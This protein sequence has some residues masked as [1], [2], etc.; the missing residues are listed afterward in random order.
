MSFESTTTVD[1]SSTAYSS[2]NVSF[3][4]PPPLPVRQIG[5][6]ES[7]AAA[8]S[9][10]KAFEGDEVSF[11]FLDTP[12]KK[13]SRRSSD[14]TWKLHT[15]IMEYTVA[16]HCRKGLVL[17]IGEN[18]EGVAL[19][20]PPGHN[21][22]DWWTMFR[23]GMWKL[24]FKLSKEGRKRW[25]REFL[26]KLHDTKEEVMAERDPNSWYL[27]YIGVIPDAQGRGYSRRL[28]EHVTVMADA[29]NEPCYVESSA[30]K[31]VA[32]YERFGFQRR[33]ELILNRADHEVMLDIMVREPG[34]HYI[35]HSEK[36]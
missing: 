25:F 5:L 6:K 12:D 4:K 29:L 31:N 11:Y 34:V 17:S 13:D 15:K 7:K 19:W 8:A 24:Y 20:M 28:V 22:D 30:R 27:V 16:A 36:P 2:T 14:A 35:P 1:L 10:A 33:T 32:I 9:L 3:V 18:H 26:P 21:M 23:S